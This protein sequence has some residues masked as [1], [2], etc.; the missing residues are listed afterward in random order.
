M[1]TVRDGMV[2]P[3]MPFVQMM[4]RIISYLGQPGTTGLPN[5]DYVLVDHYVFP[6]SLRPY[7]TGNW[8]FSGEG[9]QP[10]ECLPA[11]QTFL[12][13]LLSLLPFRRVFL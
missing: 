8:K 1:G 9:Q 7:F 2:Y 3:S 5:L 4:Q 12:N 13:R 10:L 11:R 6:E